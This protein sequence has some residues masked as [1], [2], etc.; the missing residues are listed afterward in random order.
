MC[1]DARFAARAAAGA[2]AARGAVGVHIDVGIECLDQRVDALTDLAPIVD[3]LAVAEQRTL[4]AAA[5][6]LAAAAHFGLAAGVAVVLAGQLTVEVPVHAARAFAA[7]LADGVAV[8]TRQVHVARVVAAVAARRAAAR[9]TRAAITARV[10]ARGTTSI[11]IH[12]TVV[13]AVEC[14]GIHPTVAT[15]RRLTLT[16]TRGRRQLTAAAAAAPG[17]PRLTGRAHGDRRTTR[18][19]FDARLDP[20]ALRSQRQIDLTAGGQVRVRATGS[21]Q[22]TGDDEARSGET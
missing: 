20:R 17:E 21:Q 13:A 22:T 8:A 7:R 18:L 3:E 9:Q 11:T 1:H 15:T 10:A 4:L 16:M 6:C 14:S 2:A 12:T 19:A 5:A